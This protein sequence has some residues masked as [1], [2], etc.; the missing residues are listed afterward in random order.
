MVP[1]KLEPSTCITQPHDLSSAQLCLVP[2][3]YFTFY[4]CPPGLPCLP[5]YY[6]YNIN[7]SSTTNT[8]QH[9]RAE[10]YGRISRVVANCSF[11]GFFSSLFLFRPNPYICTYLIKSGLH[12]V[13]PLSPLLSPCLRCA[14]FGRSCPRPHSY[15]LH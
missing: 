9:Y 6:L 14:L 7:K 1:N 13:G 2:A 3:C 15:C 10:Q 8:I 5:I 12:D 4:T 11:T